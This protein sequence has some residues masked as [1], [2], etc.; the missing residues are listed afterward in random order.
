MASATKSYELRCVANGHLNSEEET[1]TYCT[2]CESVLRVYYDNPSEELS[3][4]AGKF[5]AGTNEDASI[6][7]REARPTL[8]DLRR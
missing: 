5:G 8:Q 6:G 4:S 7:A 1:T 3:I 2:Q